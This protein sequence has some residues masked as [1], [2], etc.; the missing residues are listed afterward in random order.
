MSPAVHR[1]RWRVVRWLLNEAGPPD[2][3]AMA[4]S[5]AFLYGSGSL[6]VVLTVVVSRS[7]RTYL[8][9][10]LG[11]A[12]IAFTVAAA[13][14]YWRDRTQA[15]MYPPLTAAGTLLITGLNFFD[16]S[17]GSAYSLLYVWAALY[18]FYFY[19][20]MMAL[21]QV[22]WIAGCSAVEL[23]L[24]EGGNVPLARWLMIV[25]TSLVAGAAVQQLVMTVRHLADLDGLTGLA[26][27][28]RLE[29]ELVRELVRASRS[30]QE[31]CVI[32]LDLDH[33]KKF[34][35]ESR[36]RPGRP[37]PQADRA[38]LGRGA[39]RGR[40]AGALRRRGVRRDPARLQHRARAHDCRPP[41]PGHPQRPE[42]LG[43]RC[44]L[45]SPGAVRVAHARA[46]AALY[47]AKVAGRNR[48]V[49]AAELDPDLPGAADLPQAWAKMLPEVL[50]KRL[51]RFAY[52]PVVRLTD[53]HLV[54]Y[55]ALARPA[56][57]AVERSVEGLSLPP[58]D[59]ATGATWTGCAAG[60]ASSAA[61]P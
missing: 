10:I 58:S 36:P 54:G 38:A 33:F 42:L 17:V 2:P 22:G 55:E 15:W 47:E 41:A 14:W 28:R 19:R 6:L 31:L 26:N 56:G 5:G 16:A 1:P 32:M 7:P 59:S 50:E 39:A 25:G 51:L 3:A 21:A 52:Q 48:T 61:A 43:R 13:L 45:G 8:P 9:G 57:D 44:A 18:A 24:F 53:R 30:S 46:D 35:D 27:R 40:P 12:A 29:T 60:S 11:V 20:P 34:N 23:Y 37:P 49:L 4:R